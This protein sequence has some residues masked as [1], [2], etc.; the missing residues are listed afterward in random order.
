MFSHRGFTL[1]ELMIVVAIV[2]ILAAISIPAYQEY[3][4]RAEVIDAVNLIGNRGTKSGV[5]IYFWRNRLMP[6]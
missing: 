2:G 5:N 4:A 1:V 6:C 3:I